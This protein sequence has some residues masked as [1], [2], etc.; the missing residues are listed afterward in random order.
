MMG[1]NG[2]VKTLASSLVGGLAL[3]VTAGCAP[4]G[5]DD[6]VLESFSLDTFSGDWYDSS[7]RAGDVNFR[8]ERVGDLCGFD[9]DIRDWGSPVGPPELVI[10]DG[11]LTEQTVFSALYSSSGGDGIDELF[12]ALSAELDRCSQ[13]D[14]FNST[15]DGILISESVTYDVRRITSTGNLIGVEGDLVLVFDYVRVEKSSL[16]NTNNNVTD[17]DEYES[18]GRVIVIGAGDRVL[19]VTSSGRSWENYGK[20]PSL[21][22]QNRVIAN[23]LTSALG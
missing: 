23:Q 7:E 10:R 8:G 19:L 3:F 2:A 18:S 22:E 13:D 20:A 5:V 9:S 11:N 12:D 4:A 1:R 21:S 15:D 6:A 17:D 14:F 16:I